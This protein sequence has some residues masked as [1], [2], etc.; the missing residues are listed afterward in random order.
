MAGQDVEFASNGGTAT[1][2][3]A[4]PDSGRG[5]G[6]IVIQEWWGLNNQIRRTAD[7]IARNGFVALAP[8]FFHGQK[9]TEPD[10]AGKLMMALNIDQTAR[11]ARGAAEFLVGHAAVDG[12]R[13]GVIGY[14]MGGQL[15]LLAATVE[16]DVIGAVVD[17]YGVHPNVKPDFSKMQAAAL[18]LF[19]EKDSFVTA[20]V[21]QALE[22]QLRQAGVRYQSHTY[23]GVDHAFMNDE[24]P[25]VYDPN[26]AQDAW[27]RTIDFLRGELSSSAAGARGG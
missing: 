26:S 20:E 27:R 17:M 6:V 15:A 22:D 4:V 9:A 11:D 8:D 24:R 14:C 23:P 12:P 21:R 18:L 10:E 3:L 7:E 1:G 16:P 19:A 25:E 2:Y 5:R 13:V